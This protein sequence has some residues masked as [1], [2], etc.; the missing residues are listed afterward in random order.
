MVVAQGSD[1]STIPLSKPI[2]VLL[3]LAACASRSAQRS[4]LSLQRLD[5]LVDVL[6]QVINAHQG[7]TH[8]FLDIV[9]LTLDL[10]HARQQ[11]LADLSV[12]RSKL[13]LITLCSSAHSFRMALVAKSVRSMSCKVLCALGG[14]LP[15]RR[16]LSEA[17]VCM[18]VPSIDR[19]LESDED[20]RPE[21]INKN[22]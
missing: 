10:V 3:L 6:L 14:V 11:A 7:V 9:G 20:R 18:G 4:N 5:I 13:L 2:G 12:A 21:N 8:L 19:C 15:A 16:F 17:S 22:G 1:H